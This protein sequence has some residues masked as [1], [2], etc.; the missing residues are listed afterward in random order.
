[1]SSPDTLHQSVLTLL[2]AALT[3]VTVYDSEVPDAPPADSGGRV[4]PYVVVYP[5]G[6]SVDPD[7]LNL[8]HAAGGG[9]RWSFQVTVVGG[10]SSRCLLAAHQVRQAL[11]GVHLETGASPI[12]EVSGTYIAKDRDV[13]PPRF[14]VPLLF[15][16]QSP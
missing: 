3:H 15:R 12:E 6:G 8:G 14:Y 9:I 2:E 1:M 4:W 16:T 13:L 7:A 10:T 5:G 11:A